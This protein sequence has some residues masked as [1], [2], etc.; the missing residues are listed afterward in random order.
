MTN[1]PGCVKREEEKTRHVRYEQ[2]GRCIIEN[3]NNSP[4]PAAAEQH[5]TALGRENPISRR[6]VCG[7]FGIPH[8][9]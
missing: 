1:L 7:R 3:L 5:N 2:H 4:I 8:F 6:N 9:D